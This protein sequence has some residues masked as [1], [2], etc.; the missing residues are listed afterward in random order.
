[1]H[2]FEFYCCVSFLCVVLGSSASLPPEY[3][4][5]MPETC[6]VDNWGLPKQSK[7]TFEGNYNEI[8]RVPCEN[9]WEKTKRPFSDAHPM[10]TAIHYKDT[11]SYDTFKAVDWVPENQHLYYAGSSWGKA[12]NTDFKSRK[13]KSF[14][15]YECSV[16][17]NDGSEWIITRY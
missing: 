16:K 9:Q 13:P 1:M 4:D 14:Y 11:P 8:I 6:K 15:S 3:F 17:N 7:K 10:A 12:K 5:A 2:F